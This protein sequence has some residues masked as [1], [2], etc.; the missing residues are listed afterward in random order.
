MNLHLQGLKDCISVVLDLFST[1]LPLSDC[2]MFK[3]PLTLNK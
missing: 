2:H 1:T 3:A